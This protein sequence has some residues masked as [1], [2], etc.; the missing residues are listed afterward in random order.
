MRFRKFILLTEQDPLGGAGGTP[1]MGGG[2]MG[3]PP[4]GNAPG[5]I[6]GDPLGGGMGA[7]PMPGGASGGPAPNTPPI[8]PRNADV[9]DV[10]DSILNH[11]TLKHDKQIQQQNAN[12]SAT[13]PGTPSMGGMPP[14][15]GGGM[16]GPMGGMGAGGPLMM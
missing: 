12:D 2:P 14:P 10:L 7:P 11:K 13:P 4:M 8:I 15:P 1:P 9:W 3:A 5:G 6:G 16:A